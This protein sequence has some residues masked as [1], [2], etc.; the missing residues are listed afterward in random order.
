MMTTF[1]KFV[2]RLKYWLLAFFSLFFLCPWFMYAAD[3]LMRQIMEPS[4]NRWTTI[5]VWKSVNFVWRNVIEW[6]Y[7]ASLDSKWLNGKSKPSI[8]VKVTRILLALVI[9]LSVTM[10][11]YNWLIYI[12]QTWQWKE[13][14]SLIKNVVYIVIGILLSLFSVTIITLLQSVST[15]LNNETDKDQT[16]DEWV[17]GDERKWIS[18]KEIFNLF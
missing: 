13:G 11:L 8:I 17:I 18:L 9:A 3:D 10:I 12:V 7:S 1:L 15:T 2:S 4:I 5:N 16:I 6:W 14:K